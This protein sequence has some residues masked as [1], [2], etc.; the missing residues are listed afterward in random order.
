MVGDPR[1]RAQRGPDLGARRRSDA[2]ARLECVRCLEGVRGA[3]S[4]RRSRCSRTARPLGGRGE[5]RRARARQLH[6]NFTT[7]AGWTWAM[8]RVRRSCSSCRWRLTVARIAPGLCPR[9]GAGARQRAVWM[10][11]PGPNTVEGARAPAGGMLQWQFPSGDTPARAA[12]SAARIGSSRLL[13]CS[14]AATAAAPSSRTASVLTA[15]TTIGEEIVP[16]R[17]RLSPPSGPKPMPSVPRI[18]IDAMGGDHGSVRG[19]RGVALRVSRDARSPSR[20]RSSA[21]RPRSAPSSSAITPTASR[22]RSCTPPSASTW[23]RRPRPRRAARA[24]RRS[25]C[26][27][28]STRKAR[29]TRSSAPATPAAVVATALLG[30]GRL[31]GVTRPALAAFM[32]NPGGGTV[33]LD[34]GANAECK[35]SL[36]G[37]VRAHGCGVRALPTRARQPARR[38]AVDRRGRTQRATA[39]CSRRCRCCGER[40][41]LN[42]IGNVEGRDVFKGT[43]R[44]RRH[45]RLHRQRRAQDGRERRRPDLAQD[46]TRSCVATCSRRPARCCMLP[47]LQS[48]QGR[49]STGRSTAPRRCS[50]VNGVCFIGHGSSRA[51]AFRSAIRMLTRF[52]ERRVNEHIRE[53]IQ[54]DHVTAA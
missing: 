29:S 32:P 31:E 22:S 13:R 6:A 3:R 24:T 16:P 48:P 36:P 12:A 41:H 26:S 28:S 50:G 11:P 42:F 19:R 23:P 9:C 37:A 21:T 40:T 20:S 33:V 46:A 49:R 14:R 39:S 8:M 51:K 43:M 35:P 4:R 15:A 54:A 47:A 1:G 10:R 45:R 2:A 52:V 5:R 27:P 18:G 53:E 7:A 25:A 34:V 17:A 30:L 38:A 44:R